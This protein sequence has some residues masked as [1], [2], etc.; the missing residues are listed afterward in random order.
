M[1]PTIR[2]PSWF[3]KRLIRSVLARL[4]SFPIDVVLWNGERVSAGHGPRVASVRI[5]DRRT[6]LQL[7]LDP[8]LRFGDAYSDGAIQVE[9]DLVALLEAIYRSD[10]GHR[11]LRGWRGRWEDWRQANSLRGSRR[12]VHHH[13]DIRTDFYRRWLDAQLV[14]TCAYFPTPGEG[15]EQA[16]VAKM[17][18]VCRKLRL[19]PG[20]RV[21][22]AGC[23]WGALALHMARHYGA[24][25]RA[26]NISAEQIGYARARARAEGLEGQVEFVL[27]DYRN[28]QGAC[29]AFVSVGMLEHVGLAHYEELGRILDRSIGRRGRGFLHF[30]GRARSLPLNSWIRRRIFPG[31]YPPTLRQAL[32]ILEPWGFRVLDVENLTLHYAKTIEHWLSRFERS[33]DQVAA[34]FEPRFVRLWR[35]YLAGSMV[36]FRTGWLELFQVAFARPAYDRIPWTRAHLHPDVPRVEGSETW[37]PVMS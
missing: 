13:Y 26:F 16:Q 36:S 22:E 21:I 2:P 11:V 1:T 27:D 4:G 5:G 15:L 6:L 31:A 20:E 7:A 30:I 25:V 19:Q 12:N 10:D 28:I 18:H 3:E 34:L 35:L 17:D 23:G 8:D 14:Y 32:D 9:G 37:I 24:T 29:D 33:A